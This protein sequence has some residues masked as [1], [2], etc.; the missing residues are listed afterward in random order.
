[1]QKNQDQLI[2]PAALPDASR[3]IGRALAP[4]QTLL[5][6]VNYKSSESNI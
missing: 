4:H 3:A 5:L 2:L 1:M 6:T